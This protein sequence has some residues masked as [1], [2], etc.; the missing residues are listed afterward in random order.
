MPFSSDNLLKELDQ[1]KII[2]WALELKNRKE[3]IEFLMQAVQG[4]TLKKHQFRNALHAL[5]RIAFPENATP[6]L[7]S[8]VD[9]SSHK[10]MRVRSEA[11]QL[12]IGLVRVSR[13]L[14]EPLLLSDTQEKV[15]QKALA[16]GLT[17]KVQSLA[18]SFFTK[19]Q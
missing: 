14:K 3:A 18:R 4:D 16:K 17:P 12:L 13:D 2:D 6:V 9:L 1:P 7:Q 10:D 5:F 15:L 11:V 19:G 8:F